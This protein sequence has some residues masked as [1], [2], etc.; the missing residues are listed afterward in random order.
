MTGTSTN[1]GLYLYYTVGTATDPA[2]VANNMIAQSAPTSGSLY[3]G[4][5]GYSNYVR[6]YHNSWSARSTATN[7][8][9]YLV[10]TN[11]NSEFVN[12][13]VVNLGGGQTLYGSSLSY[14]QSFAPC[15]YNNLFTTGTNL[16][17][18]GTNHSNLAAWRLASGLDS[19]SVS[20]NPQFYTF[21]SLYPTNLAV[22]DLGTPI[23]MI[24]DDIDGNLRDPLTPD[25]GAVEFEPPANDAGIS[26]INSP[27]SPQS[28]GSLS[29]SATVKNYGYDNLLTANVHWSIDGGPATTQLWTGLLTPGQEST[30]INLGSHTFTYGVYTLKVWT[31]MPNGQTDPMAL[32]DTMTRILNICDIMSGT[33]T[34]GGSGADYPTF[35]AALTAL[36]GCG[37]GAPVI[38]NVQP[39]TYTTQVSIGEIAG[40]SATNTVTFQSSTGIPADV[41]ISYAATGTAENFVVRLNGADYITLKNMTIKTATTGTFG[42][43]VVLANGANYNTL[44]VLL[45]RAYLIQPAVQQQLSI[46]VLH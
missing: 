30:A 33:Y 7:Y 17:Y 16:V 9:I 34:I 20:I 27:T 39:G 11:P 41:T 23:I 36:N 6:I 38:F 4:Y 12:N 10:S 15:N 44:P 22:N 31:S 2:L 21:S 29:I 24:P 46:Q 13:M 1:Y 14:F 19:N 25:M 42:Y 8:G 40:A 37:V 5:I 28:P 26:V 32:N 35:A 45:L 18:S 43:A 3:M